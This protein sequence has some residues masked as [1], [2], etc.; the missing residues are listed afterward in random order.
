[1][2]FCISNILLSKRIQV[3]VGGKGKKTGQIE[4]VFLLIF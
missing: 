2:R 1:M 3:G 4:K